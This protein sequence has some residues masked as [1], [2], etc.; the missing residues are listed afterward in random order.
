MMLNE[1]LNSSAKKLVED[2]C[3]IK[4]G[5]KVLIV[6]N[7]TQKPLE[8]Q[9]VFLISSA[10]YDAAI[11]VGANVNLIVQ[12]EKKSLDSADEIVLNG[13]KTEPDVFFSISENKLG[14]DSQGIKNPYTIEDSSYDH[15]FDY[16][17]Y[18]KKS[19]RA[20]WTPGITLDMFC[21]T[22][23]IDYDLLQRRCENLCKLF[24]NA[25]NVHVTA[26]SGTDILVPVENRKALTDDGIFY[27]V[28]TGGNIPAGEVFIS[29]VVGNGIDLGCN[30]IIVFDG[31]ISLNDG[32]LLI[33]NPIRVQVE[34]GFV[35]NI[36]GSV[37]AEKLLETIT[38][39]E[40]MALEM[41]KNGQLLSGQGKVYCKNARNIGELG[42]GLNPAAQIT[43]N[44]LEDE[45]AFKTCHFAIGANYDGDAASLIHL[46]GVVKNPTI[47]I[48]YKNGE[49]CRIMEDGVLT[50]KNTL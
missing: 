20:V 37:E 15:I 19:M 41:E 42:I 18:G 9:D 4:S 44:M 29:P 40:K 10:I 33:K 36:A 28:G 8:E 12:S 38:S 26:P 50:E 24:E 5:E 31:S 1:K 45:K 6:T 21:R 22:V 49:I 32:D 35:K 48:F 25:K 46:D 43:G 30:G 14:K 7:K 3:R 17:L 2:I 39:A 47:D 23:D 16:L 13:L 27:Q 34:N 11:K